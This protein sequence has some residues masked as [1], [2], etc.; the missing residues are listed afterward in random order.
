M[1]KWLAIILG[2]VIIGAV[3]FP[4]VH[5]DMMGEAWGCNWGSP[6]GGDFGPQARYRPA[7]PS[8]SRV[9]VTQNQAYDILSGHLARLN[10]N[11]NVGNGVDVGSHYEFD[12]L[13]DGKT[14]D[15]VAVDKSTGLIRP[16]N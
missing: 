11:L 4:L 6:G 5:V 12:I 2:L 1:S 13:I 8:D 9:G 14:V 16:V 10:P 15:R 3:A 7:P